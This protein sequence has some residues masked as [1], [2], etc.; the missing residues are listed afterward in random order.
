[1]KNFLKDDFAIGIIVFLFLFAV[2]FS[3]FYQGRPPR[4]VSKDAPAELFS[5]ERAMA[6]LPEICSKPHSIGTKEQLRVRNYLF[7]F[8]KSTGNNPELQDRRGFFLLK[9]TGP[10]QSQTLL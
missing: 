9:F 2:A 6:H 8:L 7:D 1:M 5:A 4:V 3:A 10:L